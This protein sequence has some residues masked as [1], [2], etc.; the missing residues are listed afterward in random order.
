MS[1]LLPEL[2]ALLLE[3]RKKRNFSPSEWLE[4]KCKMLNEYM[5]KA[6]LHGIVINM[7]GGIDSSCTAGICLHAMKMKDS[8]IKR[9][10]GVAQPIHVYKHSFFNNF[11]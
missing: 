8:P 5:G 11:Q 9:V 6:G 4:A 10:V 3:V 7:S 2:E 1:K